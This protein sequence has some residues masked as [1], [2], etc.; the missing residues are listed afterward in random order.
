LTIPLNEIILKISD[1]GKG[2]VPTVNFN[3]LGLKTIKNRAEKL[4]GTFKIEKNTTGMTHYFSIPI[5]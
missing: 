1:N 4:N 3:G 5:L 2:Y